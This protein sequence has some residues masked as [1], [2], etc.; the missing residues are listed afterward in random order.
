MSES[1]QKHQRIS[2]KHELRFYTSGHFRSW[3]RT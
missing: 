3:T 1:S 2:Q